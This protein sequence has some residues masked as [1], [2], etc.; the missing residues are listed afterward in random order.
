ML[1]TPDRRSPR[2]RRGPSRLDEEVERTATAPRRKGDRR[3]CLRVPRILLVRELSAPD[4]YEMSPGDVS[5]GGVRWRSDHVPVGGT[6]EVCFRV[7]DFAQEVKAIAEVARVEHLEGREHRI[8]ATFSE[9]D[10]KAELA[11]ARYIES[12]ERLA[13]EEEE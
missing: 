1:T 6:V 4:E 12:R 10:V 13:R 9:L 8:H 5:L 3:D 2:D 7:P 11:L